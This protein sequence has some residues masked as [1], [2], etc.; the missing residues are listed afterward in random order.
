M[1]KPK[2]DKA[3]ICSVSYYIATFIDLHDYMH[4]NL[5]ISQIYELTHFWERSIVTLATFGPNSMFSSWSRSLLYA[6]TKIFEYYG[7]NLHSL[8]LLLLSL[9]LLLLLLL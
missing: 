8:L 9:L 4:E 7:D 3:S 1:T 5:L 6:R 2:Y